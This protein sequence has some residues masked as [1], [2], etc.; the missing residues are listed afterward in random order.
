MTMTRLRHPTDLNFP[1]TAA[2]KS[3]E[4]A[5]A[6]NPP[7]NPA[8]RIAALEAGRTKKNLKRG[9]AR[10]QKYMFGALIN[11]ALM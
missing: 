2:N 5:R 9:G 1:C 3:S 7:S 4:A 11:R 10:A 6:A 8:P